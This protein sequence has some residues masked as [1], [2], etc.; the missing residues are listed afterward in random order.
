MGSS[1]QANMKVFGVI[2]ATNKGMVSGLSFATIA[3]DP[4]VATFVADDALALNGAYK[5]MAPRRST[6][7]SRPGQ[8]RSAPRL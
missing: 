6:A 4:A 8:I 2:P 3:G 5:V 1:A 7:R